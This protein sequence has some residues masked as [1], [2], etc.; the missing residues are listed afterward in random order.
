MTQNFQF[1]VFDVVSA[2]IFQLLLGTVSSQK[3]MTLDISWVDWAYKSSTC[4]VM[5]CRQRLHLYYGGQI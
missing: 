3:G 2:K 1:C 5:Y 4:D